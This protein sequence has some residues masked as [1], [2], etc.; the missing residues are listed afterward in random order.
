M[1]V[2]IPVVIDIDQAFEDAAKMVGTAMRPLQDT[3]DANTLKIRLKIDDSK[4]MNLE[5]ILKSASLSSK[6]LNTALSDVEKRIMSIASKKNGFDMINGLTDREKTLLQAYGALQQKIYGIGDTSAMTQK[7]ITLNVRKVSLEID[8][9]KTKIKNA[10]KGTTAFQNLNAKLAQAKQNLAGLTAQFETLQRR[11]NLS[12]L[13]DSLG[14]ANSRLAVLLKNSIRLIALHSATRF[15][16]NVREVAAEFELQRVALGGIIQDTEKASELFRQIK[17]AA[18]QSPFQIKDLVSYTKQ[19]SA[20]RVETENLFGVTMRLADV[21]AGLGVD[22]SRLVLAYGQVRAASVLRGQELRQFTEAGIPLVDLL[23]KKFTELNGKMVS[24]ADVFDLISRRAVPFEMISEIFEDMTNKGGVFYKMQEKQAETLA[25]QWANLKDAASIMYDEIG[26]TRQVHSAME[27]VISMARTLMLN[28]RSVGTTIGS[29]ISSFVAF[30]AVSAFIPRL[31]FD[32]ALA[33]KANN[34]LALAELKAAQAG[35][36]A[37]A[38]QRIQIANLKAYASWMSKAAAANTSFGRGIKS[39][40]ASFMGGGWIKLAVSAIAVLIGYLV[41]ARQEA[42]RLSKELQKI[43]AEGALSV[44]RSVSNFNRLAEAAVKAADG[45]YEQ[46]EA[47]KEMERTY[48]DIIPSEKMQIDKLREMQG[49]YTSLTRAIEEKINMQLREQKINTIEDYFSGKIVKGQKRAKRVLA[50]YGLDKSQINAVLEEVQKEV[51]NGMISMEDSVAIRA[52][53]VS[54]IIRK[55]TGVVVDFGNGFRDYEGVWHTIRDAQDKNIKTISGLI[56][57]YSDLYDGIN[58]IDEEMS[59]SVG[60]MGIYAKSWE[61][62]QKEINEVSVSEKEFGKRD[63][64]TYKKEKI[65]KQVEVLANEIRKAFA[66]THIDISEAFKPQG[67]IDFKI[68]KEAAQQ[69]DAWGLTGLLDNI[70]KKYEALV[71]TNPM[72]SVIE[73]KFQ[74]IANTVGISMDDVQGYLL[75]GGK[76]MEAY[77]KEVKEALE[78]ANYRVAE[79]Q[80]RVEDFNKYPGIALPVKDEDVKKAQDIASFLQILSEYLSAFTKSTNKG[81][82]DSRLQDLKNDISEVTNA[83]KKFQELKKYKSEDEALIEI[84][85]LFPQLSG[86]KPTFDNL[87]K[88]LEGMRD[89]VRAKIAKNPKD[90][91]LLDMQ[92]ALDTEI[93]N[94]SFEKL[95]KDIDDKLKKLSEDIKRSETARNFFQN[96]LD[97]TGDEQMAATMSVSVYGGIGE[98]FKQRMQRQLNEALKGLDASQMTDEIRKALETGDFKTIMNNLEK[99]PPEYQKLLGDVADAEQAFHAKQMEEWLKDVQRTKTYAE[100]RLEIVQKTAQRISEI[101]ESTLPQKQKDLLISQYNQK[102]TK[103]LAKLEYEAFKDSPIYIRM[104]EELDAVSTKA[105]GNMRERLVALKSQWKD[106]DPTELKEMQRRLDELDEQLAVRNPFKAIAK[107]ISDYRKLVKSSGTRSVVDATAIGADTNRKVQEDK[108]RQEEEAYALAKKEYDTAMALYG[109]D[110]AQARKAKETLDATRTR[111]FLQKQLVDRSKQEADAAEETSRKYDAAIKAIMDGVKGLQEWAGYVSDAGAGIHDIMDTFASEEATETFDTIMEGIQKTAAG[112]G[113]LLVGT[114]RLMGGDIFGGISS[115][116]KG[117]GGVIA[118]IFGTAKKL[119]IAE[120]NRQIEIQARLL[121]DL[122]E[123]YSNLE[124]ALGKSFGSD[125]IYNYNQQLKNL[126]AQQKAA[127][128]QLRLEKAKGN[129]ASKDQIAEYEKAIRE[130]SKSISEMEGKLAE[131]FTGTD[132]TSAS[133]QFANSWIEAYK[134]FSSTTAAM[135]EEFNTMVQN[136]V[137]NSIG[138]KLVQSIL[139][140]LFKQIDEMA[141]SGGEFSASEIAQIAQEA[142]QYIDQINNAMTTM[143]NQLG[144]AGYNMRRQVGGFTGISRN[145]ANASEESINGLAAG[146]NTQNF[147]ISYV[148]LI[149]ADVAL[150]REKLAGTTADAAGTGGGEEGPTYQDQMLMYA[151]SLPVIRDDMAAIRAMLDRVI[152]PVGVK[153]SHYVSVNM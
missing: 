4:S 95:K 66:D 92:R 105:L 19:L 12:T 59:N 129:K 121:D 34:A 109:A 60:S 134:T 94:L 114:A 61:N 111:L 50:Q 108:L 125:Y 117:L 128:E 20:Y 68:L 126:V 48:G 64:F 122:A 39:L 62:I 74:E 104:F 152:K 146:I 133:S 137:S 80:K 73:R 78:D 67:N 98:D 101:N 15:I 119:K 93:S 30:K 99:F 79:Y 76:D 28:W 84:D 83:Y 63:T 113:D 51:E 42:N 56:S 107:G 132:L 69:T 115:I 90:K 10:D 31:A 3:I 140:P 32:T 33:A 77:A 72:V 35:Q 110:S 24:T 26:N 14:I 85:K 44:N 46:S 18:I 136:M 40:I 106:L 147:Y 25:G 131:F 17:A 23:A 103:D 37:S 58:E 116:V 143:M 153:S 139:G 82:R 86:W 16:R 118:G 87:L 38:I 89:D 96:I 91:T 70:Q 144:A 11:G 123:S 100:K 150:I 130:A 75:R 141:A 49:T 135:Q 6:Q 120:L 5:R 8:K 145:I 124:E 27:D 65:R 2:H 112:A 148:P 22:M 29:V 127:E 45:S 41:S 97:L 53:K 149:Y 36:K 54:A 1:A 52:E 138:A 71:P 13:N 151:A 57:T 88:K 21:S 142:P 43:G 7:I 47:L 55:L 102:Q 81:K 9:L